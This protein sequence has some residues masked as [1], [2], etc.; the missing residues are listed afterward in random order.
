LKKKNSNFAR[1]FPNYCINRDL[2]SNWSI[3][4]ATELQDYLAEL[5]GISFELEG[6]P[7]KLNFVQGLSI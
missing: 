3:D 4:I 7:K 5:E 1:F 2:A 6:V